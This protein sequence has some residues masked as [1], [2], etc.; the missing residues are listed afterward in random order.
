[1]NIRLL[2]ALTFASLGVMVGIG[3]IAI[4]YGEAVS[5][6]S[7]DPAACANC[8]IMLP[9]YDAWQKASHHAVATC[10]DCHLPASFPEKYIAKSE[11]GWNHSKAFTLQ[12]FSEPIIIR[13]VNADVLQTNCLRCHADIVHQQS[14]GYTEGA[15]RC[16]HCHV[17]VGHG[18]PV[19]L[20]GPMRTD[21][22]RKMEDR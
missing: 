8:H 4:D 11:N 5:Y 9:Q 2:P 13:P 15:P 21:S 7:T 20:G 22:K 18:E 10:A 17:A 12:N 14:I 6:L 16:V 19:G 1:M 3:A